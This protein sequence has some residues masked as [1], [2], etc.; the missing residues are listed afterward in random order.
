MRDNRISN[1]FRRP[2]RPPLQYPVRSL[3]PGAG[4]ESGCGEGDVLVK[5]SGMT[6]GHLLLRHG[7]WSLILLGLAVIPFEARAQQA[8]AQAPKQSFIF[9]VL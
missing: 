9:C 4:P 8:P 7:L 6:F 2:N 3:L 5:S 1:L